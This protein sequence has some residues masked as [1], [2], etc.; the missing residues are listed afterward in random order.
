[1]VRMNRGHGT[2][3]LA[4]C[5]KQLAG[6]GIRTCLHIING[7]PGESRE[8]MLDTARFVAGVHPD[9]VKI[10][11]PHVISDSALGQSYLKAPSRFCPWK[12]TC[13]LS[14]TSWNFC[15]GRWWW[16]GSPVMEWRRIC[17]HLSGLRRSV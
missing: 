13:R 3:C 5:M 4:A 12:T 2:A 1:M 11:M 17:W 8:D 7:A 6:G 9:A 14:A 16:S 15:L 10:H